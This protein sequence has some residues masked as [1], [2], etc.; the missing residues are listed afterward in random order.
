MATRSC[1]VPL[2]GVYLVSPRPIDSIAAALTCSGV[3]K[4]GSPT[5]RSR[6][7]WPCAWSSRTRWAAAV[8][9]DGL[10]RLTRCASSISVRPPLEVQAAGH[11]KG[12]QDL[13]VTDV[14]VAGRGDG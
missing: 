2:T 3:S 6:I 8:L 5:V 11:L 4:S 14:H 9:G 1:G 10:M 13:Q 7:C 12:R